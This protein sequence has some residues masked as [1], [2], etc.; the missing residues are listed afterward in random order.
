MADSGLGAIGRAL[1]TGNC[2]PVI[3][4]AGLDRRRS[5]RVSKEARARTVAKRRQPGDRH[6]AAEACVPDMRASRHPGPG[7][8]APRAGCRSK[9]RSPMR[10]SP[11]AL[12]IARATLA[13]WVGKASF[14]LEPAVG[15]LAEHLR[16]SGEPFMDRTRTRHDRNWLAAGAAARRP[17]L[18]WCGPARDG[19][20]LAPGCGARHAISGGRCRGPCRSGARNGNRR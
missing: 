8:D 7:A 10:P 4:A 15:R 14:R 20:V 11:G 16:Q 6:R 3:E 2:G 19:V 12:A 5:R 17:Q 1:P 9:A 13:G 18:G